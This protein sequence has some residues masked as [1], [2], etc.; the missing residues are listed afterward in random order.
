MLIALPSTANY[1]NDAAYPYAL[2][3]INAFVFSAQNINLIA[4]SFAVCIL[5]VIFSFQFSKYN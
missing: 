2:S 3:L 4:Q 1:F 5:K